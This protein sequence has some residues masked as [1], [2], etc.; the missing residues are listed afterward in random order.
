MKF[1][2]MIV[3][4]DDRIVEDSNNECNSDNKCL[5]EICRL[6][7]TQQILRGD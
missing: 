6:E 7:Y 5:G 1:C 3:E 4:R 2:T